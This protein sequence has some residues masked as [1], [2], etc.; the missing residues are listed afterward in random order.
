[1]LF[2]PSLEGH[3]LFLRVT[4]AAKPSTTNESLP[5]KPEFPASWQEEL[6]FGKEIDYFDSYEGRVS[7]CR[8]PWRY[9]V[10]TC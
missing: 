6:T 2:S 7:D 9:H 1:M 5:P 3:L 10:F 4:Q 8:C